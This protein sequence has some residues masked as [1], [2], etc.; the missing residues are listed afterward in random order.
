MIAAKVNGL[1]AIMWLGY[2]AV[3]MAYAGSLDC[4]RGN[5]FDSEPGSGKRSKITHLPAEEDPLEKLVPFW[6]LGQQLVTS[7]IFLD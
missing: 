1:G 4:A 7:Y 5:L 2:V 6:A 3:F